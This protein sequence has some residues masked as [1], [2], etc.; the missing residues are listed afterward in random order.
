MTPA[1]P[2]E[3]AKARSA[4]IKSPKPIPST[5]TRSI[6][7]EGMPA[8]YYHMQFADRTQFCWKRPLI[9]SRFDETAYDLHGRSGSRLARVRVTKT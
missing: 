2:P 6:L 3:N 4:A 7:S 8:G 9:A 5:V 1:T